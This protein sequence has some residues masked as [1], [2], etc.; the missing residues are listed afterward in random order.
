V[1]RIERGLALVVESDTPHTGSSDIT[2]D[3]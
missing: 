1:L 2:P 3:P